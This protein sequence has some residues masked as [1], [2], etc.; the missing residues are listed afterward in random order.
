MDQPAISISLMD[1]A[2]MNSLRKINDKMEGWVDS[3]EV[4]L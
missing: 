3:A 2:A 1:Y 4:Q